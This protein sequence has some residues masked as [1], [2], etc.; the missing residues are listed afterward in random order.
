MRKRMMA[1]R[2]VRMISSRVMR[3]RKTQRVPGSWMMTECR[4]LNN[5]FN[6]PV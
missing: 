5:E 1:A 3:S 2:M 4:R 6:R